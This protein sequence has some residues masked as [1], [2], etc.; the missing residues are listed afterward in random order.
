MF[1]D[2]LQ[3]FKP[4][5]TGNGESGHI[6]P[7]PRAFHVCVAI[8]CHLFIFG[9]RCGRKRSEASTLLVNLSYCLAFEFHVTRSLSSNGFIP[10]GRPDDTVLILRYYQVG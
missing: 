3:W 2:T 5:C 9:G 8:D 1:A 7:S 6:G 10:C 4:E